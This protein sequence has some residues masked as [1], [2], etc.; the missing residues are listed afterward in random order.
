[1]VQRIVD[2]G[3]VQWRRPNACGIAFGYLRFDPAM[4][5]ACFAMCLVVEALCYQWREPWPGWP[6][7]KFNNV[8]NDNDNNIISC[9]RPS[10]HSFAHSHTHTLS[11]QALLRSLTHP[12]PVDHPFVYVESKTILAQS[13]LGGHHLCLQVDDPRTSLITHLSSHLSTLIPF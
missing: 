5:V 2:V 13:F 9:S 4:P 8:T 10:K 3:T 1:M 6:T 11:I 12:H 7:D